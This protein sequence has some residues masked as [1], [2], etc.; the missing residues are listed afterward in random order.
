MLLSKSETPTLVFWKADGRQMSAVQKMSEEF[1]LRR[2][3]RRFLPFLFPPLSAVAAATSEKRRLTAHY[4][5]P[6]AR[7]HS[8]PPTNGRND[9][10]FS[11]QGAGSLS[12][13]ASIAD[14]R[15]RHETS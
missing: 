15:K 2:R 14:E 4:T 7:A 5:A 13:G 8:R 3:R 1:S 11:A 10:E 12:H 9:P 6:L